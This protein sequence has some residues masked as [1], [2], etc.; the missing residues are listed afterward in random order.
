MKPLDAVIL[1]LE[2]IVGGLS[3]D[4]TTQDAL[5][6][7]PANVSSSDVSESL[8]GGSSGGS[9]MHCRSRR[10]GNLTSAHTLLDHSG[11]LEVSLTQACWSRQS[12]STG[13]RHSI[14]LQ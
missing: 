7:H 4:N 1:S 10:V 11:S 5:W 6:E 13:Q 14:D 12:W 8:V 9:P 2:P 3:L